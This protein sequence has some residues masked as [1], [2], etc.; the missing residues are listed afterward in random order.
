M[1]KCVKTDDIR[2]QMISD[3]HVS[4]LLLPKDKMPNSR[5]LKEGTGRGEETNGHKMARRVHILNSFLCLTAA[6]LRSLQ[7]S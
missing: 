1:L 7:V 3:I 2:R 4:S 5:G 6:R